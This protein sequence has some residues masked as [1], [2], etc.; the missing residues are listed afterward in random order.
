MPAPPIPAIQMRLP[1]SGCECDELIHEGKQPVIR[2][3]HAAAQLVV[4]ALT[5]E[6]QHRGAFGTPRFDRHLIERARAEA[7][8]RDEYN[9][10][11]LWQL[12]GSTCFGL[13]DR[14]G[15]NWNGPSDHARL[16]VRPFDR[17]REE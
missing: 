12:E 7:S 2:S 3:R 17:I 1:V 15:L 9:W 13:P 5:G 11:F 8:S 10:A 14:P 6:V 4:V 16:S